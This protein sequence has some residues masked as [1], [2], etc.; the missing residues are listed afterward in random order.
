MKNKKWNVES[1]NNAPMHV[2]LFISRRKDNKDIEDHTERRKSFVTKLPKDH[3][4]LIQRFTEFVNRGV[5]GEMCRM[6][7]SVNERD[8][9]KVY[10]DL[11]I[12]LI[13]EPEFN[14]CAISSKLAGIAAKNTNAKTKR[15]MFDFDMDDKDKAEAFCNDIAS[16]Y[17]LGDIE[18]HK[19]PNG[20]AIITSGGFDTRELFD[21][22]TYDY[23]TLKRDDLL[24]CRWMTKE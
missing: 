16:Y 2:V 6:Y 12:F 8:S 21:K 3:P 10:K 17:E 14:L 9:E 13:S 4:E 1:Y 20:Y 5:T 23:I 7:Y 19:T 24:C 15:W 11:L 18:L 22:W